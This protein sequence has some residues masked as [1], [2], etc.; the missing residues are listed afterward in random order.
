MLWGKMFCCRQKKACRLLSGH[1]NKQTCR[2]SITNKSTCNGISCHSERQCVAEIADSMSASLWEPCG[3]EG[4]PLDP[5]LFVPRLVFLALVGEFSSTKPDRGNEMLSVSSIGNFWFNC[6]PTLTS[7]GL[8]C[9]EESSLCPVRRDVCTHQFRVELADASCFPLLAESG[10]LQHAVLLTPRALPLSLLA[11]AR[12]VQPT[13]SR[14]GCPPLP[15]LDCVDLSMCEL[16]AMAVL[17][18]H[19]DLVGWESPFLFIFFDALCKLMNDE[20]L[21]LQS[22]WQVPPSFS[23][24]AVPHSAESPGTRCFLLFGHVTVL[25]DVC[26]LGMSLWVIIPTLCPTCLGVNQKMQTEERKALGTSPFL[27]L[28]W[29]SLQI[30]CWQETW[31][32]S[33]H[34]LSVCNLQRR[35]NDASSDRVS[36][37][38]TNRFS[39]MKHT[40]V[41]LCFSLRHSK[42]SAANRLQRQSALEHEKAP[43]QCSNCCNTKQ[44]PS[45]TEGRCVAHSR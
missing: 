5:L 45:W 22:P 26:S 1:P 44:D 31:A 3:A 20:Q 13:D 21:V 30:V 40:I 24:C 4:P 34:R 38:V 18:S 9:T 19:D 17:L 11:H 39:V 10:V 36:F 8:L 37:F 27:G 43:L 12:W 41:F 28:L 14:L 33:V 15:F 16:E 23:F 42:D 6:T 7:R 35:P 29:E 25:V 32:L 2:T